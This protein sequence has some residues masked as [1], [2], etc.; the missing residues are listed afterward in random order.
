MKV[1]NIMQLLSSFKENPPKDIKKK[2][3]DSTLEFYEKEKHRMLSSG[4]IESAESL[5]NGELILKKFNSVKVDEPDWGIDPFSD[6]NWLWRYHQLEFIPDLLKA[7]NQSLDPKFLEESC[8]WINSWIDANYLNTPQSIMA[9]H[10]HVTALRLEHLILFKQTAGEWLTDDIIPHLELVLAN[11]CRILTD[12]DF[13]MEHTNHGFD[14]MLILLISANLLVGFE[15]AKEWC[16]LASERLVNEIQFAFSDGGIHVENSPAYHQSMMV[17]VIRARDTLKSLSI[18]VDLN[19]DKMLSK[20]VEFLSW[21]TQPN[22]KIPTIGDSVSVPTLINLG[23]LVDCPS[24]KYLRYV[25]SE[26]E[27]G[28]PPS[29]D[30]FFFLDDGWAVFRS[31]FTK[32]TDFGTSIQLIMKS[33]FFSNWH[34]HDDD[35]SVTLHAFGRRWFID[36]GMYNYHEKE[37]KRVFVRSALGHNMMILDGVKVTRNSAEGRKNTRMWQSDEDGKKV[38]ASTD[39]FEGYRLQRSVEKVSEMVYQIIDSYSLLEGAS[40]LDGVWVQFHLPLDIQA[41]VKGD[42]VELSDPDGNIIQLVMNSPKSRISVHYGTYKGDIHSWNSTQYG[43]G[44]DSQVIRFHLPNNQLESIIDVNLIR[45]E[46]DE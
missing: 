20:G 21:I 46:N 23:D 3:E 43:V 45:S 33:S 34:R 27:L 9:W 6:R 7:Y 40:E 35:T 5:L 18:E 16:K 39:I 14:Q 32:P 10:D 15:E 37:K 29:N 8:R 19:F 31:Q 1:E 42:F 11:H 12:P 28:S 22:G 24:S 13:Y 2:V 25:C 30:Y 44:E 17:G 38:Y 41:S 26:G 36:T 4:S